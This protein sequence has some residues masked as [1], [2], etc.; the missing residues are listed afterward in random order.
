MTNVV[1]IHDALLSEALIGA[2]STAVART[3]M[4]IEWLVETFGR[5]PERNFSALRVSS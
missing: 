2:L 1:S 3:R 4:T 5:E